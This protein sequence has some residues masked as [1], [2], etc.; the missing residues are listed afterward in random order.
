MADQKLK[1]ATW[2][3]AR[4]TISNKRKNDAILAALYDVDADILVLTETNSCIDLSDNYETCFSSPCLFQSLPIDGG[5]YKQGENRVTIW[6]KF[7][8]RRRIDMC[9]SHS[10]ICAELST[11][12]GK[13]NVYGTVIGIYGKNRGRYEPALTGTDFETS[14]ELQLSDWTRLRSLGDLNLCIAG[15]FNL[16]LGQGSYFTKRHR[17]RLLDGLEK[18]AIEVPTASLPDNIDQ[19]AVSCSFLNTFLPPRSPYTWHD[20]IR[21]K[22]TTDHKGVML[23]LEST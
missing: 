22:K 5:E 21:D 13:L 9:N 14:L 4:P 19:I 10:A 20:N 15:D 17:E 11:H 18:L 12:C 2:N 1:I 7:P 8:G 16:C 3:L 23:T 6:S